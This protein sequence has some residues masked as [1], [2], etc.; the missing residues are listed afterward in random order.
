M[1]ITYI[2]FC[3]YGHSSIYLGRRWYRG[4]G[5]LAAGT[6]LIGYVSA[7][8]PQSEQPPPATQSFCL[9]WQKF[10]DSRNAHFTS[11]PSREAT[12][13]QGSIMSYQTQILNPEYLMW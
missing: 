12:P 2:W 13:C 7:L 9:G 8:F 5:W 10:N 3:A 1:L 4:P 11:L 6:Q